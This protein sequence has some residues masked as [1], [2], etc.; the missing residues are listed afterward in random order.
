LKF[1]FSSIFFLHFFF[2]GFAQNH[3]VDSLLQWL[4]EN[5]NV[6]THRVMNTHRLSYRLSEIDASRAWSYAKQTEQAAMQLNFEKGKCL[7]NINYAILE[8]VEGNFERSADY[9]LKAIH[10]AEKIKYTRGLSIA[11]NNIGENYLRLKEYQKAIEYSQKALHLNRG[12]NENRGQAINLEQIGSVYFAL[13]KY[14]QAY[15]F[16]QQGFPFAQKAENMNV[17]SQLHADMG[18]YFTEKKQWNQANVCLQK[19]DSIASKSGEVLYQIFANKGFGGLFSNRGLYDSSI[20]YLKKALV[21][22]QALGNKNEACDVYNLL[23]IQYEKKKN[24]DSGFYYLRKHKAL[25]DEVLTEKNLA[26]VNFIQTQYET[27]AKENENQA[28][29]LNQKKQERKIIEKNWLLFVSM[30][31]ILLACLS[32]FLVYRV[33]Q[34]DKKNLALEE[35]NKLSTYN[36]QLAELEI[37]ALRSQMNPHFLFNS[38]NSIRNFIIKNEPQL[39]SDYLANFAKLMRKI[40]DASQQSKIQLEEEV[41]MLCLYLDLE[42]MRF[43]N[44][45][46]YKIDIAEDLKGLGISIP[47]MV[48]QPFIENAIWHGLLN[49]EEHEAAILTI[50]FLEI[51][52]V[53]DEIICEIE[54]NG[55]GREQSKKMQSGLKLHKS[56]GISI[57]QDRLMKLSK[58]YHEH[59]VAFEDLKNDKGEA[60]GTKVKLILPLL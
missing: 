34:N 7:A 55:I 52:N 2:N 38:L 20:V 23:S 6:D 56:K 10:I 3:F 49:K 31:V 5:P 27:K 54:D 15:L 39:A 53:D 33:L 48:L 32:L 16:W 42:L 60:I 37:M 51:D 11:Y 59:P 26:H 25:N 46:E 43:S 22:S 18:K 41:D 21:F 8:S 57:T 19:A 45:F 9:Y 17:L 40:L 58:H 28:L 13:K 24:F 47:S 36:Q 35:A 4:K 12:I 14:E 30:F 44:R 29:R 1:F 50:R